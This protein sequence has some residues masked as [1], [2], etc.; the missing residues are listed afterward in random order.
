MRRTRQL[1]FSVIRSLRT[2]VS[3]IY[4]GV[5]PI[6]FKIPSRASRAAPRRLL[7]W[8]FPAPP[9]ADAPEVARFAKIGLVPVKISPG[10]NEDSN[11]LPAPTGKFILML[12]MYWP[13]E[14]DP[15]IIDGTWTIPVLRR[16]WLAN[17]ALCLLLAQSGSSENL[18]VSPP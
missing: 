7:H 16:L 10:A 2:L 1:R 9:A 14:N 6:S 17:A 13:N 5:S 4:R 15:S 8:H 18:A 12:R 11:W 3:L